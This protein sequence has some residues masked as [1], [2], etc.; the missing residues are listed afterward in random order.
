MP[1]F[2]SHHSFLFHSTNYRVIAAPH[3]RQKLSA[4]L[5]SR[6]PHCGQKLTLAIFSTLSN[7]SILLLIDPRISADQLTLSYFCIFSFISL[8]TLKVINSVRGMRFR[9]HNLLF[10]LVIFSTPSLIKYIRARETSI[11]ARKKEKKIHIS[12]ARV[13]TYSLLYKNQTGS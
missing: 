5:I 9:T 2:S 1:F 12:N 11:R 3:N 4:A 7:S 13:Y 8:D 6:F 10:L